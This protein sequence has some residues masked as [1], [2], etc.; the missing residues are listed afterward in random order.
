MQRLYLDERLGTPHYDRS[1]ARSPLHE[2]AC[3]LKHRWGKEAI[4]E[5]SRV[6]IQRHGAPPRSVTVDW[7]QRSTS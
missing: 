6:R 1:P 2:I 3:L 5:G 7:R 4:S